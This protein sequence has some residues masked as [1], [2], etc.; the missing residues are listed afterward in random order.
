MSRFAVLLKRLTDACRHWAHFLRQAVCDTPLHPV[1]QLGQRHGAGL[2]QGNSAQLRRTCR[3][4]DRREPWQS[5]QTSSFKNFST[6]FMPLLVLD[7]RKRVFHG[8]NGVVIGEIQL[9]RLIGVLRFVE[10]MLLSR[11]D[12]GRRSPFRARSGRG[13]AHRCA[14]P[15]LGTHRSSATT[16]GC[17]T[18]Q[19]RHSS[20]VSES[21]GTR[22]S[23][24][25]VRTVAGSAAGLAGAL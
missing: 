21:S 11:P 2:V 23:M 6:R 13:K 17:S 20:M 10:N 4:W 8:V 24:S 14:R 19:P 12:R 15:S 1:Y 7:L 5:G 3:F 25:T 9:A 16:S 18:E 22:V